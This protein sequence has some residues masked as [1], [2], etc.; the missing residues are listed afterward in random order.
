MKDQYKTK[1]ALIRELAS[2]REKITELEQAE[3]ERKQTEEA[4]RESEAKFRNLAEST[5]TA[6]ML[7]QD[8]KWVY[9]NTAAVKITGYGERELLSMNFWDI[10]HPEDRQLIQE[11]GWKRQK[12]EA[13]VNRYEFRII[14]RDG[15][16]KWVDLA[17]ASTMLGGRPAGI[18]S[19]VDIT[20]RILV[21]Q[22]LRES[23]E[24]YRAL[25]NNIPD[26]IYSL[27]PMGNVLAINEPAISR[28]GYEAEMIVG[29]PFLDIIHPDDREMVV[30]SFLQAMQDHREYTRGL[31]FR[32]LAKDES[33]R[34]VELNS[35]MRF[36]EKGIYLQEEGVLRDITERKTVEQALQESETLFRGTFEQAAVGIAHVSLEG[37]FIRVN[38]RFCDIAGY[39]RE[40]MLTMTFQD[41][42][43]PDDLETDLNYARQVLEGLIVTYSMEKRYIRKDGLLVWANLTVALLRGATGEP[44]HFISVVEDITDHKRAEA[45]LKE[46]EN[47]Y[48]LLADNVNDVIFVLDMNLHYTYV[49]P[50]VKF[51]RGYEPEEV[52]KQ[53]SI[54]TLTP[55]SWDLAI[56]TLSEV[57]ELE[58]SGHREISESRTLQLEMTR[59]NGSTVWTEVKF[60]FIRDENQRPVGILG[61]TRDMTERKKAED[62][63]RQSEEQLRLVTDN[64]VDLVL[65]MD[66]Q[67]VFQYFTPNI[68]RLLGYRIEDVM[69]KYAF[70]FVHP[71]DRDDAMNAF[72][73]AI[74]T[75]RGMV[76][77]RLRH[78]EGHYIWMELVG[79]VFFTVKGDAKGIIMGG[80]DIT[81]RKR[82]Q[83]A[84]I[85]AERRLNDII[86]FLPDAT[87][88]IDKDG[89]VIAWNRAIESM[90]GVR[91][92]EMLG[93]GNYEYALPFYGDRRPILI[94][95]R[96]KKR[97]TLP[98]REQA[99]SFLEKHTRRHCR[100]GMFI[101]PERRPCCEIQRA[102]SLPLSSVSATI[103]IVRKWRNA[104]NVQR[105]WN[106]WGCWPAVWPTI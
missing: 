96:K 44:M 4:L 64:M 102:R 81:Q 1:Q 68:T 16:E 41:I 53:P 39:G 59:K 65:Q 37:H 84:S 9:A 56:R 77:A 75:G 94:R 90:T 87:L 21:E 33:V 89:K 82:M 32:I 23:E 100:P 66:T 34:W 95:T 98:F 106:L 50:S 14:A 61:I 69:G 67:A 80:R 10:V 40:E 15:K 28:Y 104:C 19:V 103:P 43:F 35:H 11:R 83:E 73:E 54:E 92:E 51:L 85:S 49:S 8:D 13:T 99:R 78:N 46:S 93:K 42:T 20:D 36:D 7:Y 18:I 58:K 2:L 26:V 86:E 71:D 91:S 60:S 25:S 55:S 62:A 22:A 31:Q 24:K 6:I 105:R 72:Q 47:K 17:G 79:S 30:N 101:C 29:K 45:A 12:A 48:R 63:L 38:Q 88:V 27:D 52:L 76:E 5:P 3:S 57:M 70:D 74:K 97:H